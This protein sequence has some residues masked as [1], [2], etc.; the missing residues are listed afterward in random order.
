MET[1][2]K[3]SE[4]KSLNIENETACII[5][6]WLQTIGHWTEPADNHTH[7]SV[8]QKLCNH[9]II[10]LKSGGERESAAAQTFTF[11]SHS[12]S[13]QGVYNLNYLIK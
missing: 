2:N 9:I 5:F 8:M 10:L 11:S 12:V 7:I 13:T 6:F 1:N 4:A 3:V